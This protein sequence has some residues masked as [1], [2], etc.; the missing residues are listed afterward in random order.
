MKP[1]TFDRLKL[2][3]EEDIDH[4]PAKI[5]RFNNHLSPAFMVK[6][7]EHGLPIEYLNNSKMP[8]VLP[9]TKT[10]IRK[11]SLELTEKYP[12]FRLLVRLLFE[13]H[14]LAF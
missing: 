10:K 1:Q 3:V 7:A 14:C 4:F 12:Y 11:Q 8:T 9:Y 13:Y 2:R 6:P 5:L